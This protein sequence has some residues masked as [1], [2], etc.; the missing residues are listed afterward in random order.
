MLSFFNYDVWLPERVW[1]VAVGLRRSSE[2]TPDVLF[3]RSTGPLP[4]DGSRGGKREVAGFLVRPSRQ[5]GRE[6]CSIAVKG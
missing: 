5:I 4:P 1:V 6:A 2:I 3:S